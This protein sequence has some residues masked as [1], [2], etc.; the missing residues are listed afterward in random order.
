MGKPGPKVAK[1]CALIKMRKL[2]VWNVD[3]IKSGV[4]KIVVVETEIKNVNVM[5]EKVT[6]KLQCSVLGAEALRNAIHDYKNKQE[7]KETEHE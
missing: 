6:Y 2:Y 7:N 4:Q 1:L 3:L 5:V